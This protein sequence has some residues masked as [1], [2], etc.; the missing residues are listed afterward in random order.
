MAID[1][2]IF[3][4]RFGANDELFPSQDDLRVF[5]Q[6][7][8]EKNGKTL[9]GDDLTT[10]NE[11]LTSIIAFGYNRRRGTAAETLQRKVFLEALEHVSFFNPAFK[12]AIEQY[13]YHLHALNAI[14]FNKPKG[15]I[16]SAEEEINRLKKKDEAARLSRLQGMVYERKRM[17]ETLEM[18]WEA[19]AKELNHIARYVY[20][21]LVKI[22][23]LSGASVGRLTDP[24]TAL[25]EENRVTDEIKALFK[26]RLK[27]SLHRGQITKQD[28][29]DVKKMVDTLSRE[30]SEIVRDD[31]NAL[32]GLYESIYNHASKSV[33]AL[34]TLAEK[35]ENNAVKSREDYRELFTQVEKVLVSAVS[36]Y[37]FGIKIKE[38]L[39]ETAYRDILEE[40][41]K[42]MLDRILEMLF[43]E[44]RTW[45]DRR[46][47][48]ERRSLKDTGYKGPERRSGKDRRSEKRRDGW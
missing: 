46:Y 8:K 35:I 4:L 39:S 34:N 23:R 36:E 37:R 10:Y 22:E 48:A 12:S 42:E 14:D 7:P 40:K 17:L 47:L 21:N 29:E 20:Q 1:K 6:S 24:Q 44:R 5:L 45:D 43:K 38:S 2:T 3:G 25:D 19:L 26:E 33:H 11:M 9:H 16:K 18:R 15:F 31:L 41:R 28:L 27:E 30:I 13:K 32:V